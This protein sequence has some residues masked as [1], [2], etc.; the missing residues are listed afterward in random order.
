MI[1]DNSGAATLSRIDVSGNQRMDDESI[2]IL[3]NLKNGDNVNSETVNSVAKTLQS[4]G[5][6][7]KVDAK[8]IGNVLKISVSES[9]IINMVTVEGNDEIDTED[10]KKE[11]KTSKKI[12]TISPKQC[13]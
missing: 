1:A 11:I 7:E 5:Y 9:P 13:I 12:R 8:I 2:R 4:S 6:F 10:L 3:T